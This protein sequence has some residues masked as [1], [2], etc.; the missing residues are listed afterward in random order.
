MQRLSRRP[1]LEQVR[2]GFGQQLDLAP[3]NRFHNG[4]SAW[5]IAI[6]RAD[7]DTG[8]ARDFLQTHVQTDF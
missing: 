6:Q 2:R 7:S 3:V 1:G 4:L 8:A 5:E